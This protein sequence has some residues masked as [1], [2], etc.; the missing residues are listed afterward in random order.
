MEKG[1]IKV[2]PSYDKIIFSS[3]ETKDQYSIYISKFLQNLYSKDKNITLKMIK[4]IKWNQIRK[5]F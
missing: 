5:Y 2:I 1:N 4:Q 3:N